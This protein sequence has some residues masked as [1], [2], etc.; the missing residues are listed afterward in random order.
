MMRECPCSGDREDEGRTVE[1]RR[2]EESLNKRQTR[3]NE[4]GETEEE[5][6]RRT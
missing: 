4:G 6:R 5:G 1:V 2:R 3:A